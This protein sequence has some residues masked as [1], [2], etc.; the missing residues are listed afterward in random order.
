MLLDCISSDIS[1]QISSKLNDI[2]ASLS[3]ISMHYPTYLI[4]CNSYLVNLY[5]TVAVQG[6]ILIYVLGTFIFF[7]KSR[8]TKTSLNCLL[9][10]TT[11]TL[12]V[13]Y[14]NK[15]HPPSSFRVIDVFLGETSQKPKCSILL[16]Y[17]HLD[18]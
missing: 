3:V 9:L 15:Q 12:L 18:F 13:F 11:M 17:I 16:Y 10:V 1:M 5:S 14:K 7:K 2:R 6:V 8:M 4:L